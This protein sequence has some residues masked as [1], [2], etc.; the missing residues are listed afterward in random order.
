MLL[1]AA[2]SQAVYTRLLHTQSSSLPIQPHTAQEN[3]KATGEPAHG[4]VACCKTPNTE[5]LSCLS[6]LSLF[7]FSASMDEKAAI[8]RHCLYVA[9]RREMDTGAGG[10]WLYA[11]LGIA[12]GRL[13]PLFFTL[14]SVA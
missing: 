3:S 2:V 1:Y 10:V 6:C 11:Y 8:V 5:R 13:Q 4:L 14:K 9:A 12:R 7:R